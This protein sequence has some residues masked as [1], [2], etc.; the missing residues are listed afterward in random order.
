L[1]HFVIIMLIMK[2]YNDLVCRQF[3]GQIRGTVLQYLFVLNVVC[4]AGLE[5]ISLNWTKIDAQTKAQISQRT[6]SL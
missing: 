4:S 3:N 1:F 5:I 6:P 2:S